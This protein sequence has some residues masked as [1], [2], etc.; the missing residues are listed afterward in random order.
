MQKQKQAL[1]TSAPTGRKTVFS[2]NG[3]TVT[4]A[5]SAAAAEQ[6]LGAAARKLPAAKPGRSTAEALHP[7]WAAKR[8][9]ASQKLDL[10]T[11]ATG[12]KIVFDE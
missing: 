1:L 8:A 4:A 10:T 3:Q 9:A 5:P 6:Q 7:S 12:T 2:D 11:A